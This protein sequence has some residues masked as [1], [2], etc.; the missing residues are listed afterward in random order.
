MNTAGGT[1]LIGVDDDGTV[2]GTE[3]DR[4]KNH[5]KYLLHLTNLIKSKISEVHGDFVSFDF[6]SIRDK[7]ILR[8]TCETATLPAYIQDGE[9]EY[10]YI[11]TGPSSTPL[12]LSQVHDY[13]LSRFHQH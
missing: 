10:F 3:I 9:Q 5:D 13:I 4:F 12:K 1:L 7:Q 2:V 6:E 11:R 8:V